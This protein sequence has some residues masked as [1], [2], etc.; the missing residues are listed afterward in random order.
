MRA[1]TN[2]HKGVSGGTEDT[3]LHGR[4][5]FWRPGLA[6]T[7]SPTAFSAFQWQMF[8]WWCECEKGGQTVPRSYL[9]PSGGTGGGLGGRRTVP[10]ASGRATRPIPGAGKGLSGVRAPIR[11]RPTRVRACVVRPCPPFLAA[12]SLT[13]ARAMS[14]L[15]LLHPQA[16]AAVCIA[17][18][19]TTGHHV[20]HFTRLL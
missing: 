20:I 1:R 10:T 7:N 17:L 8:R 9:T 19:S 14:M 18:P 6:P 4:T 3:G 11:L 15:G 12:L 13:A 2:S 5:A 16:P